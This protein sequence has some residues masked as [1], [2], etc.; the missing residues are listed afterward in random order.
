MFGLDD[1]AVALGSVVVQAAIKLWL[2]DRTLAADIASSATEALAARTNDLLRRRQTVRL[3]ERMTDIV[4]RKLQP[5]LQVEYSRLPENERIAA[6]LAV[7]DTFV[8]AALTD[9]DLFAH[10]LNATYVDKYLRRTVSGMPQAAGLSEAASSLYDVLLRECCEYVVQIIVTLPSFQS[11]ILTEILRRETEITNLLMEILERLP[12]RQRGRGTSEFEVDYRRQVKN[13]L[14][15]MELFGATLSKASRRYPLSVAYISLSVTDAT[16][17]PLS[18]RDSK[19]NLPH[20]AEAAQIDALGI[21]VESALSSATRLFVRGDAGRGKTS[22]LKWIAVRSALRDFPEQLAF[23]NNTTPF[24]IPLRRYVDSDPP[25]PELFLENLGRHI[26]DEM[27]RGWV[28]DRLRS[29]TAIVLID[30]VDELPMTQR[31][32]VREWLRDLIDTFPESRYVVTSRSGAAGPDWLREEQFMSLELQPMTSADIRLFIHQWHNAIKTQLS[33]SEEIKN[34]ESYER[35]LIEKLSVQRYLRILAETPL[36][37]AL[38]CALHHDR[39]AHLP[40]NRIELYEVA[41]EMLLERRDAEQQVPAEIT[42]SRTHKTLLLQDIAYWLVRNGRSEVDKAWVVDRLAKKLPAMSIAIP[43]P[44]IYRN[45]LERSGLL[46]EPATDHVDFV[47][48]SFQEYLAALDALAQDDIGLLVDNAHLDQWREVVIMAA[49][50]AYPG[51][52]ENLL[53]GLIRR[54]DTDTSHSDQLY[55][56]AVACLETSPQLSLEMRKEIRAKV[57]YL[58]PPRNITTAK[59]LALAGEFVADLLAQARPNGARETASTV[60]AAAE[61]GGDAGLEIIKRYKRDRRATVQNELIR[62][63]TRFDIYGYAREVISH[64]A[65]SRAGIT[66]L[67]PDL[68]PALVNFPDLQKLGIDCRGD[69]DL[70]PLEGLAKLQSLWVQIQRREIKGLEVLTKLEALQ[71]LNLSGVPLADAEPLRGLTELRV[72]NIQMCGLEDISPISGLMKLVVLSLGDNKI[73]DLTALTKMTAL[74]DLRLNGSNVSN[75]APLERLTEI[76]RLNLIR[77]DVSN[78]APLSA[79]NG[80]RTL[81]LSLTS[82]TD[83]SDLAGLSELSILT[84]SQTKVDDLSALSSLSKLR[85]LNVDRTKVSECGPL[86]GLRRLRSLQMSDT[87][88]HDISP[89][90]SL[91]EIQLLNLSRTNVENVQALTGLAKLRDLRLAETKVRDVSVVA[92]MPLLSSLDISHTQVSDISPLARHRTPIDLRIYGSDVYD[93][94]PLAAVPVRSVMVSSSIRNDQRTRIPTGLPVAWVF[95]KDRRESR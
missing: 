77:T 58:L 65:V 22:L 67:D 41:L 44:K 75:L 68:L 12:E 93:L 88:V 95:T 25:A 31:D 50:R 64:N 27:P 37:C 89:L 20:D 46:R 7:H 34:V 92:H 21:P 4:A 82:V 28:H 43:A 19:G 45:L 91:K 23:L 84:I 57:A 62:A 87:K 47:H 16:E 71:S 39:S 1:A 42:L 40:Q 86:A 11:G 54:G 15:S 61:I 33:D 24:F 76:S 55:L 80:L 17:D 81:H 72:L 14:D 56:L 60:R 36:L 30:G 63:W 70:S 35:R 74:S 8:K 69:I 26:A 78:L 94:T 18:N 51:Q 9:E 3:V 10:D 2:G 73:S 53:T 83:L 49:G 52:R 32:Q 6:T 48:R 5:Y 79:L 85:S 66:I 59:S 38:L 90:G 29:G 13:R